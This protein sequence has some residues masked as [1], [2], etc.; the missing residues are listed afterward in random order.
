MK[1]TKVYT[2]HGDKG[3]TDLVG[4]E[5]V[6]KA[7]RRLEAYGTV[8]ELNSHLGLLAAMI[9]EGDDQR[10]VT[11]IQSTL[12]NVCTNLATDQSTTPLYPRHT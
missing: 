11:R 8:D 1:I 4:G 9:G 3:M 2:R 6:S 5:R 12:F 7:S 10:A